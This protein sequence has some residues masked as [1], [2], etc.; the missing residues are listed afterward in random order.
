MLDINCDK[1]C[2]LRLA[3]VPSSDPNRLWNLYIQVLSDKLFE[4]I[5]C[6]WW[7][8]SDQEHNASRPDHRNTTMYC[9]AWL[10]SPGTCWNG[11]MRP[12][13]HSCEQ[14]SDSF[15]L[16]RINP[17]WWRYWHSIPL[18]M[19]LTSSSSNPQSTVTYTED[20]LKILLWILFI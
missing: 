16:W 8:D 6:N 2:Q 18:A 4:M 20:D 3:D 19:K 14:Y 15:N 11:M 5:L 13:W 9:D 10:L 7:R 12:Q 1:H 17:P